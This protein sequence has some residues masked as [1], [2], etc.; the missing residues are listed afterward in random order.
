MARGRKANSVEVNRAS[1]AFIKNPQR[2]NK[3]SPTAKRGFPDK[4]DHIA[5]NTLASEYWDNTCYQLDE[6]KL[7]SESDGAIIETF[8]EAMAVKQKLFLA[9]NVSALQKQSELC[10]KIAGELGLTPS[11]R[12]R[13]VV[14][15]QEEEDDFTKWRKGIGGGDN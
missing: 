7:L 6:L 3:Q 10:V 14:K 9:G 4:P 12:S 13:L 5:E 1:G 11:A 15:D 2:E 8:V